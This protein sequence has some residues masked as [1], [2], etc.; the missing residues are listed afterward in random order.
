[1]RERPIL[2]S[3]PMVRALLANQKTQTRRI[4]KPQYACK[5]VSWGCIAG[6]GFG[7]IFTGHDTVV[8]CPHGNTGDR[9][10]VKE[11]WRPEQIDA[12]GQVRVTY[13][14]GIQDFYPPESWKMPKAAARGNVT[15]LFMPRWASRITLEITNVRVERL[16]A[17]SDEDA[18][19][20]GVKGF[21]N[22]DGSSRYADPFRELW[23]KINGSG[24][25]DA[26]PWVWALTFKRSEVAV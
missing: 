25:W 11:T 12:D 17:I 16:Q 10:W 7:F 3:A 5:T 6:H 15:S 20:E 23:G 14:D 13:V 21:Q 9:L 22:D 19:S 18:K 4:I 24:S 2:F 26:N 8:K 1:M